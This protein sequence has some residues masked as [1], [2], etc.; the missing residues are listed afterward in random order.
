MKQL[1]GLLWLTLAT[2]LAI[3]QATAPI[4][5]QRLRENV[6]ILSSDVFQGRGPGQAGD[7]MTVEYLAK[8]FAAAG[9]KPGGSGGSWF[10]DVPLRVF[11]R[12]PTVSI[13]VRTRGAGAK[14]LLPGKDITLSSHNSGHNQL[15]N[16]PIVFLGYGIH[17]PD[18]GWDN[19]AGI[20]LHGKL[21]LVWPT[22]L[23][24]K[25]RR[26]VPP[27]ATLTARPWS[28]AAALARRSRRPKPR[29]LLRCW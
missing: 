19:F 5:K 20:D 9:L 10:Q 22:I 27:M 13:T 7:A 23:T 18:K 25:P 2:S 6:R 11:E 29:A 14:S 17:A 24:S 12:Q 16:V 3:A 4:S 1:T 21:A 26:T 15:I 8:K 28:L